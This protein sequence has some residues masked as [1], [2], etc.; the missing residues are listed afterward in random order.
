M[1]ADDAL[2]PFRGSGEL[3]AHLGILPIR[4]SGRSRAQAASEAEVALR[5]LGAYRWGRGFR[6]PAGVLQG[7]LDEVRRRR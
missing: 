3:L 6:V 4:G 7:I 1:E 5:R 2:V